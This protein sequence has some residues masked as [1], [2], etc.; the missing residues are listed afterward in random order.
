VFNN[1]NTN[2]VIGCTSSEPCFLEGAATV[3]ARAEQATSGMELAI[4]LADLGLTSGDLPRVIRLWT[5]VGGSSGSASDQSLPSMRNAS[6]EGNQVLAPGEAP[7][8]FTAAAGGPSFSAVIEDFDFFAPS[9]YYGAWTDAVVTSGAS[10]FSLSDT[11]M[12]GLYYIPSNGVDASGAASLQ[13]DVTMNAGNGT[14]TL[15]VV[16]F[17]FDGTVYKYLFSGVPLTGH[18]ILTKDLHD[19]YSVDSPGAVP[20]LDLG[21]IGQFNLEGTFAYSA[22]FNVTYHSITLV[23]G[24]RNYEARA[25]RICLGTVVGDADCDG[26]NDLEDFALLQQCYGMAADPVLPMECEQLDFVKNH[27]VD[28]ADVAEFVNV[29]SGP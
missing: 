7:V 18:Q 11:S 9:G 23:G 20:G 24:P 15:V 29:V 4:P 25:A 3:A 16:L 28:D 21:N 8:N 13:L 19:V 2:G 12:G 14:E 26:D 27:V 6:G 5:M 1:Q 22:A 17:D 10:D